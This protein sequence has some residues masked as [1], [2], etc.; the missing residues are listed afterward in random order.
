MKLRLPPLALALLLLLLLPWRSL[1]AQDKTAIKGLV[2][3]DKNVALPGVSVEISGKIAKYKAATVTDESGLFTFRNLPDNNYILTF[4]Y[5]GYSKKVVDNYRYKK[6]EVL[7]LS[8]ELTPEASTLNDV[9]VVG[10]GAV[11]KRD[12]TGSVEK[13]N[14]K[15]AMNAPVRSFEEFLAGRV[16][17]VQ[18]SSVD[19][20][21]G[22]AINIVIRGN[23]SISQDN[24]PLYV[25]DGFPIENPDNNALNPEDIENIEVLKDASAT[26]IYGARGANGV[27][28]ISTKRGKEGKPTLTFSTTYGWQHNLKKIDLMSPYEY[29]RY[30][31]E[32][33]DNPTDTT[34]PTAIYLRDGKTPDSY[35][36]VKGIDWQDM[37]FRDA[38]MRSHNLSL[39]GGNKS[40]R[41][42]ISGSA[43]D[44]QGTIINSYYK[45]YQGRVRL[46][47]E[48]NK[49]LK[50]GININYSYLLRS[51]ISPSPASNSVATGLL[52][53]VFGSAPLNAPQSGPGLEEELF[54]DN[55]DIGQ[56]YRINPVINQRNLQR[57][58]ISK[59]LTANGFAEYTIL[60]E[61]KLR[62][63]GGVDNSLVR[64]E[65]FN[66]SQTL[67]GSKRTTLGATYGV[68]G[69][70]SFSGSDT[71]LNE[72]TLTWNKRFRKKHSINV[73]A[74]MTEQGGKTSTYGFGSGNLPN[75]SLGLSGLDEGTPM[76]SATRAATSLWNMVSFLGRVNYSYQS[77]Y[78]FTLSYRADASSKF[79]EGNRWAYFPSGAVAWRFSDEKFMKGLSVLSDGK[80]RLTY[81][82]TGNN[83]VNDFA[84]MATYGL[85]IGSTY[86][87]NN[88]Y[89]SSMIPRTIANPN[90]K[91]ETTAQLNAGLDLSFFRNLLSVTVDVYRKRTNDLLL[92]ASMPTS[93]G[94]A[95]AYKNIGSMQNQG[96]ELAIS[97]TPVNKKNFTWNSSFNISFN[98]SK[99][100]SLTEGQ[101]TI[102]AAV[103]WDN[104]WSS[105]PAYISKIGMPLGNIYGFIWDGVYGYDDFN[106]TTGGG[107]ILK[108]NVPTNGNTRGLIKPGDIKYRDINGDGVVNASDY[109]VI[110]RGLPIH[111]GGFN[112]SFTYKQF[113]LNIFFQWSYGND[114]LNVNR[115]LFE[116]NIFKRSYLNQFASYADRWTPTNTSSDMFRVNGYYGGGYSSRTVEDGSYLR[117]KT[118]A[119]GYNLPRNI[120]SRLKI[121]SLRIYAAAQNVITWTKYKGMDPEVSTFNSVLTPG[122][123]YSSYPRSRT[124]TFGANLSF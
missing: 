6:N 58:N 38:P 75:E 121:N 67:Y 24:S 63:S 85:P 82:L 76:P 106:K 43:Y 50:V 109:T 87:F 39:S 52:Y 27:I 70:I 46:D 118:L 34:S 68:N 22:S 35:K 74:G 47:Q 66:N 4:S 113:D 88:A 16:A 1:Q 115:L 42:A 51:G 59:V 99:V 62:V 96:L 107:Y 31:L 69:S 18:V 12:L 122:F 40:T 81:G 100:L 89:Q 116:G 108:D 2:T 103:S 54:D 55:I 90:L 33:D 61:L 14:M 13:V 94:Y 36:S 92:N 111:T 45:R 53:G 83:R 117:L 5:I 79:A 41:Y 72:N 80:L 23:N 28:I 71:W 3:D 95:A 119:L 77:K 26:A 65:S 49:R 73:V 9:M 56:D 19:G 101:E 112:N 64:Y 93:T 114:I 105:L 84:Y 7:T 44:Q 17:G 29:V 123:D 20:Q 86:I 110:G 97:A 104:N 60:P 15:D 32:R 57:R 11:R 102:T 91:W 78:L 30:Q 124:I 48:V 8:V 21:P 25:I 120:T 10:Y 98:Q 37:M